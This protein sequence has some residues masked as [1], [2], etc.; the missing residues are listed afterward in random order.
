MDLGGMRYFIGSR[1][2][3]FAHTSPTGQVIGSGHSLIVQIL[4]G[5]RKQSE[6]FVFR[7][8]INERSLF[9][10]TTHHRFA[11]MGGWGLGSLLALSGTNGSRSPVSSSLSLEEQEQVV[12]VQD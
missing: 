4:F 1:D 9:G 12:A 3:E 7:M 8:I 11:C 6:N 2:G 10:R 5:Y